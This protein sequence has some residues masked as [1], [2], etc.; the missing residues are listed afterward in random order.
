MLTLVIGNRDSAFLDN[1]VGLPI[2]GVSSFYNPDEKGIG[3]IIVK[4][5]NVMIGY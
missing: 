1:S 3:E 4:G 5:N 2:P